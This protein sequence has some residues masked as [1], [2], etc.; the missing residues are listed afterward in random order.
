MPVISA[1]VEIISSLL[2]LFGEKKLLIGTENPFVL[3]EDLNAPQSR[4]YSAPL[5]SLIS[6]KVAAN[7]NQ[8]VKQMLVENTETLPSNELRLDRLDNFVDY[9]EARL[10]ISLNGADAYCN[11][12]VLKAKLM[13]RC[14]DDP[15]IWIIPTGLAFEQDYDS[16][17]PF[18]RITVD[19][20]NLLDLNVITHFK[21][22]IAY[23]ISSKNVQHRL[24]NMLRAY[25]S[26]CQPLARRLENKRLFPAMFNTTIPKVLNVGDVFE[27]GYKLHKK[28]M[29]EWKVLEKTDGKALCMASYFFAA[30]WLTNENPNDETWENSFIRKYLNSTFLSSGS[31]L[32]NSCNAERIVPV[33]LKT[34]TEDSDGDII[35]NLTETTTD[36]VFILS[37]EKFAEHYEFAIQNAWAGVHYW[38]RSL[39]YSNEESRGKIAFFFRNYSVPDFRRSLLFESNH[40]VP[41]MV[42]TTE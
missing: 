8:K 12:F 4:T 30:P 31:C 6:S 32:A 39:E 9:A 37:A 33:E 3:R 41:C 22:E 28:E 40:V 13:I 17:A 15:G 23:Y 2:S 38:T 5:K 16:V 20:S 34:F 14:S 35:G 36:K 24:N 42:F 26:V 29:F 7:V 21:E 11:S 19:T 25:A 1:P 27:F 10:V 18:K